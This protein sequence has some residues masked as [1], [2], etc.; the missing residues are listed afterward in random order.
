VRFIY[1]LLPRKFDFL[2]WLA[3]FGTTPIGR[4]SGASRSVHGCMQHKNACFWILIAKY[5]LNRVAC[6]M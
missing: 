3:G 5:A 4:F 2:R 6:E 1:R